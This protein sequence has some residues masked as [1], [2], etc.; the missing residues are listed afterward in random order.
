[1]RRA[2]RGRLE[3]PVS[4]SE[5][6]G[7]AGFMGAAVL[8]PFGCCEVWVL[9]WVEGAVGGL[10]LGAPEADAVVGGVEMPFAMFSAAGEAMVACATGSRLRNEGS[11]GQLRGARC[12]ALGRGSPSNVLAVTRLKANQ[13]TVIYSE[14]RP[15][16]LRLPQV[17]QQ[18]NAC[19]KDAVFSSFRV[20]AKSL[21]RC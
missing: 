18:V 4:W 11:G 9:G 17:S 21:P 6:E 2:S 12:G 13:F 1:M 16:S 20:L 15:P 7:N 5:V 10:W 8:V 19:A 14:S 3:R